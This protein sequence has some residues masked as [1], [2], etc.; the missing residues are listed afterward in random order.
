MAEA[1]ASPPLP[2][3]DP[4]EA[5]FPNQ[6]HG[7]IAQCCWIQKV[8][9]LRMANPYEGGVAFSSIVRAWALIEDTKREIR[10]IPKAGQLNGNLL[11]D[12][13]QFKKIIAMAR[14]RTIDIDAASI[15]EPMEEA[16]RK[17]S[18]AQPPRRGRRKKAQENSPATEPLEETEQ[19]KSLTTPPETPPIPPSTGCSEVG[20]AKKEIP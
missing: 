19:R 14:K 12:S 6:K 20:P 2:F 3:F 4:K 9:M 17:L 7:P 16:L 11:A 8:C 18:E 5:P 1:T 10:G 15:V 13:R